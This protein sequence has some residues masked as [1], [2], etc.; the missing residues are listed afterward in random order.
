MKIKTLYAD[1]PWSFN[2]KLDKTRNL[3]YETMSIDDLMDLPIQPVI[4]EN[5]HF[6]LWSTSSHIHQALHLMEKWGFTY[7]TL[8]P[9]IK[10][11]KNGKNHFGMG[12]YFRATHEPLL[13]GVKGKLGTNTN[14]TRNYLVAKMPA[15]HSGKPDEMYE[16]IESN[17]PGPYLELFSRVKRPNWIMLG[18]GIDGMDIQDS[19]EA[20]AA[21]PDETKPITE[22]IHR[23]QSIARYSE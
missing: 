5:A 4:D 10:L 21:N 8:I 22:Q 16:M 20:L 2:D 13:F 3:S 17:S 15:R 23:Q 1:P 7:K 11:T 14:N 19:L 18:D 6:Y 9:W 12:H